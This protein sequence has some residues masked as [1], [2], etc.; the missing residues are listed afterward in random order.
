VVYLKRGETLASR[1]D[2]VRMRRRESV[3]GDVRQKARVLA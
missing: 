3:H 2:G 1:S